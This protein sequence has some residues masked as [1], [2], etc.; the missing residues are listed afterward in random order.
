MKTGRL[1]VLLTYS[2]E[3]ADPPVEGC[4]DGLDHDRIR[5]WAWYPSAPDRVA[6]VELLNGDTVLARTTAAGERADLEAAGKR[7]G[8]CAFEF[9]GADRFPCGVVLR[10]RVA[11]AN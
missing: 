3:S 7:G 5:G 2:D 9:L 6:E 8:Q 4:L 1:G 11:G 10:A